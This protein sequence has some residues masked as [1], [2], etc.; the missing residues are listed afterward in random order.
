MDIRQNLAAIGSATTTIVVLVGLMAA[1]SF[2][3][4]HLEIKQKEEKM[5]KTFSACQ[6]TTDECISL[7]QMR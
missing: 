4:S 2:A 7:I 6:K 1:L 5:V 3:S